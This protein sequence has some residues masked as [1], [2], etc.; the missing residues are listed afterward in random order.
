MRRSAHR[1]RALALVWFLVVCCSAPSARGLDPATG[2]EKFARQ[3]WST[4]NGLPQ[5]SVHAMLQTSNG[6]LWMATEG[7]LARFNGYQFRVFDRDSVPSLPG[8]DVRC[9]LEDRS[10]ALWIGTASGLVRWKDGA[11]RTY[12]TADGLPSDAVRSLLQ[13]EDGLLWVLTERGLSSAPVQNM[14]PAKLQFHTFA[15]SDG[16]LSEQ[17]NVIADAGGGGVWVGTAL[18]L[19]RI[20]GHQVERGPPAALGKPIDALQSDGS[21]SLLFASPDGLIQLRDGTVKVLAKGDALPAGGSRRVLTTPDG[22]WVM[23]RNGLSLIQAHAVSVFTPGHALPGSQLQTIFKDRKG[24]VWIATNNGVARWWKGHMEGSSVGTEPRTAVLS[25]AEDRDGD[26]W[27]GTETAG[28]IALKER[29]FEIIGRPQGLTGESATSVVEA[30]DG[31]L[32]IGTNGGGLT[33]LGNNASLPR[34]YTAKDGLGSDTVLALAKGGAD[35]ANVWIGT[36]DGL[37]HL[38]KNRL[39]LYGPAD[40]L[41]D[42]FVRSLLVSRD[43]A[44]WVGTRHG[45]TRW[46]DQQTSTW[47]T[48]DGLGSNLIGAMLE[49]SSGDQWIGTLGGLSRIHHGAVTN[50]TVADGLPSNTITALEAGLDGSLWVGTNG[51][52]LAV[53]EGQRFVS[54]SGVPVLPKTVF[55]ILEDRLGFLW[56]SSDHGLDRI[57]VSELAARRADPG[58]EV[59]VTHFGTADGLGSSEGSDAGHPSAERLRDGRLC[60]AT[61]RGIV[62]VDP[63]RLPSAS[64]L[65]PVVIEQMTVD[66]R[67]VNREELASLAPGSSHLSFSFAG[68]NLASPQQLQYR[69]RLE[70]FDP[71]WIDAGTRRTAFYTNIPPGPYRF[72]VSARS[73]GGPWSEAGSPV[74]I[75]LRPHFYQ[76]VWFLLLLLLLLAAVLF[77]LYRLRV[78]ALKS[79]F[80]AVGAERNRLAREIHDTLAQG[81]VAVSVR[82]EIMSQILRGG[83][84]QECREQ[85]DETRAL[86]HESL[87]EARRSIWDLRSEGADSRTLPAR[88]ARVVQGVI[89]SGVDAQLETTGIYRALNSTT[90]AEL[91]RIAQEAV[92]NA[93]RHA[94]ATQIH[95]RL[96][97][98]QDLVQLE[99]TDDGRGF[100]LVSAPSRAEGHFGLT[101]MR[102][103]AQVIGANIILESTP[104]HGATVRVESPI[105]R[106]DRKQENT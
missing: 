67:E 88:L 78:Q 80:D 68:I 6:Y 76:T 91:Y 72:R 36:P 94:Q 31:S 87:A 86:V 105:S 50:Y 17:V 26:I 23:G 101:G 69:Y 18:G 104:G 103:R 82:L 2:L 1:G 52:G 59:A 28:A 13:T 33:H 34:S 71:R 99:V 85:L 64:L 21:G 95:I 100:D 43:G 44:L 35:P 102:E 24:A 56:L 96:S 92:A 61:R 62:V 3:A 41:A 32:W 60:F 20:R 39:R 77:G 53:R 48:A 12:K 63:E 27:L 97:Y 51:Q 79:R 7:G 81:F 11:M 49:D 9:L 70:G 15:P 98:A 25:I 90:E 66:D 8:N 73:G 46:K 38:E 10:G 19:N 42:D 4:E 45:L 84:L 74:F 29:A 83:R 30:G 58:H 40:G 47:T 37:S 57:S 75:K 22:V 89:A 93:L 5:N 16:M 54:F 55:A 14:T 106:V 65:P